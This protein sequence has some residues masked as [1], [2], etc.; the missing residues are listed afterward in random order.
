MPPKKRFYRS[1][2][3]R[4]PPGNFF[5]TFQPWMIGLGV[6]HLCVLGIA[7]ATRRNNTIQG[8]LLLVICGAV[9]AA[10]F[11]NAYLE[12]RWREVGWT[13][14]YF[15]SKGAF[16]TVVYSA[17]LLCICGFLMVRL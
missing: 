17:P 1:L 6:F 9:Y 4:S 2:A 14:P 7:I 16:I 10:Q 15:D 8:A 5:M 3:P 12:T 13:Q 11:I